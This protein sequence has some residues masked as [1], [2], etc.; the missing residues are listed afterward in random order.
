[1]RANGQGKPDGGNFLLDRVTDTL[2]TIAPV[3]EFAKNRK[4][5]EKTTP[6]SCGCGPK[7][8]WTACA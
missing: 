2:G 5:T 4:A 1:M 3:L 8:P 7:V 6:S